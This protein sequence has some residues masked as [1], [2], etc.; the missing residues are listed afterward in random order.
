LRAIAFL[1]RD[2]NWGTYTAKLDGLEVEEK[3]DA[4]AVSYRAL[5]ADAKQRLAY[6][7]RISGR[8]DGSLS[9][10][11]VAEPQTDVITNRTGFIVLHPADLAGQPVRVTHVDG[12][13]VAAHF[14]EHISPSQPIFDIRA[15]SHEVSSGLWAT[16]RMEG[17]TFEMEDQRNWG[18]AS[19]KTYVRPLSLP[20]G[21]K[22]AKG[23]RHEQAIRLSFTGKAPAG[24][25][26]A[27]AGIEIALGRDLPG[28]M[29]DLGIGLPAEKAVH[30]LEAVERL[31]KLGPAFSS[32]TSICAPAEAWRSLRLIAA[33]PRRQAP[34][35]SW[36][37]SFLTRPT[38]Q[39]RWRPRQRRWPRP[40]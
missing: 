28:K 17:D 10:E 31:R 34:R 33:S 29:P 27:S 32:A 24:G 30:A 14:P 21:Y 8:S 9:F 2:E 5:C 36:R 3:P 6:R 22:L 25:T 38:P 19:Y 35:S 18:D 7:A 39:L 20:W 23:S 16:C 26:S 4:F 13:E 37:S 1:V 40:G 12:R 15:L 11:A